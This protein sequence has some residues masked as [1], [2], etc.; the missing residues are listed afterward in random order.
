M[1]KKIIFFELNEVPY[2]VIDE[3]CKRRPRS[4][5]SVTLSTCAQFQTFAEDRSGLS[6]W[7]TWPSV[8]RGVND[9]M[10]LIHDFGQDL[11]DTD[12]EYPP[13]WKILSNAG[14]S[15]GVC[16]SLHSYPMPSRLGGYSFYLPDTFAA[17]SECFPEKLSLFQ[18][19]NLS[20]ARVSARNV[21]SRVPWASALRLLGAAPAL[22][23]RNRTF[24]DIGGQLASEQVFPWRTVR[25]RT[26]QAVLAF[27]I[28]MHQLTMRKPLFATFFTN[29]VASSM[30][31]YWAA[32]FPQDYEEFGYEKSWV[33]TYR[34]EIDFSM[35]KFDEFLER[36]VAFVDDESGYVLWIVTSMG[37]EATV[38]LPLETQLYATDFGRLAIRL[39]LGAEDWVREPSML[40]QVN[41]RVRSAKID[42][43]R[44]A[45]AQFQI[46]GE[47]LTYRESQ[48]GFFSLDF[49]QKNLHLRDR[50]VAV[51]YG[52][53]APLNELG[54]A[55]VEIEDKSGTSAYHIPQGALIIYDPS[56]KRSRTSS[57]AQIS[58]LELA[59]SILHNYGLEVPSYMR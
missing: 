19:F 32:A 45:L 27:D 59:P 5:L 23:L 44:K 9:E 49:G 6:P 11:R 2:R 47:A 40:P 10:H 21:D 31:R 35:R 18:E 50:A 43:F 4:T 26:Y 20:M 38:A 42:A 28:F 14:I 54:L 29:H 25:R 30:H 52:V 36:L 7:K 22:G 58:T 37:Q 51:L 33:D 34:D 55:N 39:G 41:L 57:R 48:H 8:H 3:F 56:D 12:A 17:G 15:S 24:L 16:G 46:A 1:G 13:I 53:P